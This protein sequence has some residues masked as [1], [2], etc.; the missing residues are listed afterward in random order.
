MKKAFTLIEVLVVVAIIAILVGI[1]IPAISSAQS[2][3]R[4]VK[5]QANLRSLAQ[6]QEVYVS[7]HRDSLM[8]P[9]KIKSYQHGG[10]FSQRGW[11]VADKIGAP[12]RFSV[13][14]S[15]GGGAAG[16][17][18][19][20]YS[21]MYA[22]HWYSVV[23]GW[24]N[25]GDYASEVQFSPSDRVLRLRL[26]DLQDDP[27]NGWTL[28]TGYWDCSY[29]LSPTTWF[30]PERYADD[31]RPN[32]RRFDT[33]ASLARRGKMS[34]VAY[35]SQKVIMWERFDWTKKERVASYRNPAIGID[36]PI[37]FGRESYSPQ[38]NNFDAEPSVACADGSVT[39][40]S[41]RDIYSDIYSDDPATVRAANPTDDWEPTLTALRYYSMDEDGFEIGNQNSGL[42]KYPAFFWAT[43][44]GIRGRDFTR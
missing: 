3:A 17:N 14:F 26:Q 4:L 35:P 37:I 30:A 10:G 44:D 34:Q 38:W 24:L 18:S 7:E 19:P 5:S 20:Y 12:T 11:G 33:G 43:R 1:L 9:F 27:P 36:D 31:R 39:R 8:V 32:A 25:A 41:I 42:G 2:S 21:E 23:G 22:F 28:D 16:G 29:I 13:E 15:Y 40:V 6:I